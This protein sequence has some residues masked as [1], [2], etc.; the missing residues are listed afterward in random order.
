M[1]LLVTVFA[2]ALPA[3]CASPTASTFGCADVH[4]DVVTAIAKKL[5]EPGRLR[6]AQQLTRSDGTR[7]V[8]AELHRP[9]ERKDEDGDI[10]TWAS[11]VGATNF[12]AVDQRARDDSSWPAAA[13]DVRTDGAIESRACTADARS[14]NDTGNNNCPANAT[15]R[16]C[17]RGR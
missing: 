13:L 7:F 2:V 1:A 15:Q 14:D 17:D 9:D 12:T 11:G 3:A 6:F 10:L 16:M 5:D 4:D 8:S